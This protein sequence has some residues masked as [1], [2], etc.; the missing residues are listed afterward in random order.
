MDSQSP[1]LCLRREPPL[2]DSPTVVAGSSMD[3]H[4]TGTKREDLMYCVQQAASHQPHG[5][6]RSISP[7][8]PEGSGALPKFKE[9][10]A[11]YSRKARTRE[12][13]TTAYHDVPQRSRKRSQ[14][15][16]RPSLPETN[17]LARPASVTTYCNNLIR[18]LDRPLRAAKTQEETPSLRASVA[19]RKRQKI[20]RRSSRAEMSPRVC[21]GPDGPKHACQTRHPSH[22]SSR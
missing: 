18:P 17:S 5:A 6:M 8:S 11:M 4:C 2:D 14:N 1:P 7:R 13:R 9:C 15:G 20:K 12:L 16:R 3:C 22:R 21:D 19:R 10:L